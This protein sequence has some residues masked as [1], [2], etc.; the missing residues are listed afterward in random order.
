MSALADR[1]ARVRRRVAVVREH[2]EA[3]VEPAR[4]IVQLGK[5]ILRE[6]FGGEEV[7][8]PRVGLLDDGI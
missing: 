8:S 3:I 7:E 4:Q 5:L 2:A 6:R 1:F